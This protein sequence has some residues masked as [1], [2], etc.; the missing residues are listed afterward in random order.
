MKQKPAKRHFPRFSANLPLVAVAISDTDVITLRGRCEIISENGLGA[1]LPGR[2]ALGEIVSLE[3]HLP[4]SVW[5]VRVHATVRHS[6]SPHHGLEF[7]SLNESQRRVISR[8]C[9]LQS[10]P[11]RVLMIDQLRKLLP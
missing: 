11:A 9:E 5:P 1:Q 10:Q 6:R 2:I 3:L 4:N 7:L 8:Y